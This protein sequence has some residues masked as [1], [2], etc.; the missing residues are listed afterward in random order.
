MQSEQLSVLPGFA[1]L[2]FILVKRVLINVRPDL[3][4]AEPPSLFECESQLSEAQ[5]RWW[6]EGPPHIHFPHNVC[7]ARSCVATNHYLRPLRST[8]ARATQCSW[9]GLEWGTGSLRGRKP[10]GLGSKTSKILPASHSGISV[11]SQMPKAQLAG[12]TNI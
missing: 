11:S 1:S 6:V 5:G 10:L 2:E 9:S 8:E 4:V 12:E 7:R 3:C